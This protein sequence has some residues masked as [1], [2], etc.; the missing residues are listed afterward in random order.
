MSLG[1]TITAAFG[2]HYEVTLDDGRVVNGIPRGKKSPFACGDHVSLGPLHDSEAQILTHLPRSSLLY[3]SDAWKQKLIAANA[4]QLVLVV[5]TEPGFSDELISRALVAA[6]HEHMR[7]VI[8]LNKADLAER[9]PAARAQLAPFDSFKLPVVELSAHRDVTPLLPWL[10]G[11][12][13]VLVGQSGM[14]KST[15]TNALIPGAAA[16]TRE[17]STALDSGKHTTTHARLYRLDKQS[18]LIDSPGL[19]EF[20]LAHLSFGEIEDGFPEFRPLVAGC[21][22]RDC[23]HRNEPDCAVKQGVAGGQ[24]DPRRYAH[25][26]AITAH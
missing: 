18:G 23:R 13:S 14:G 10:A 15:I 12:L 17:I 25:F 22:F 4:T 24:V 21:R 6:L 19:Q 26:L 16:A 11:Q 9:L 1:G 7:V 3:R 8:A 2:R 5:A 20:G